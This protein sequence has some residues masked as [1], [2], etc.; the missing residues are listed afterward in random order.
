MNISRLPVDVFKLIFT[1]SNFSVGE[2]LTLRSVCRDFQRKL[3]HAELP[4]LL[5]SKTTTLESVSVMCKCFRR[6]RHVQIMSPPPADLSSLLSPLERIEQLEL[7][8]SEAEDL[9]QVGAS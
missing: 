8:G 5:V 1:A 6:I 7:F 9:L 4:L 2:L 3:C